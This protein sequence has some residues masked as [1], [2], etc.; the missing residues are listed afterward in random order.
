MCLSKPAPLSMY[1]YAGTSR[2]R[3][4]IRKKYM[5][6]SMAMRKHLVDFMWDHEMFQAPTALEYEAEG[7]H[8]LA[9]TYNWIY[10]ESLYEDERNRIKGSGNPMNPELKE[11]KKLLK[12]ARTIKTEEILLQSI[13]GQR[14]KEIRKRNAAQYQVPAPKYFSSI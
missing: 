8:I 7:E 2:L 12:E 14:V 3:A 5:S 10:V 13:K 9:K 1:D 11:F 6:G 4:S